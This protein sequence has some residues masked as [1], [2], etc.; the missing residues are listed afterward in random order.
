MLKTMRDSF[1]HLKWTLW[2]VVIVFILGFV[3][4]S[5]SSPNPADRASQVVARI[6]SDEITGAEFE[7]TYQARL[8][9]YRQQYRGSLTPEMLRYLD[10][11]RQ[12]LEGMI[13]RRLELEQ[14]RR[15]KLSVGNDEVARAVMA[16][17]AFQ[18]DGR[19]I[20]RE[21]Y[22]QL[23]FRY[24]YTPERFEEE[25]REDLLAG[26][27]AE[28]VRA[29]I[30]VP[31]PE[32][33]REFAVRNEKATIEYILVPS[34]RLES[35]VQPTDADLKAYAEKHR[36]RY[37]KP[38]QRRIKYL[39]IDQ[40]KVRAKVAPTDAELRAEYEQRREGLKVPEQV[41]AAHILI[42]SDST[43]GAEADAAA[44]AKAEKLAARARAG[45]DFA[46]L[47]R[48]SSEDTANKDS[49]GQL[50]PFSRGQMVPEF[51]QAAFALSPGQIAGP[52]K[53][54]F[55]YHVIKLVSKNPEHLQSFEEA[56]GALAADLTQ[57]KAAAEVSR[58][59]RELS[60]KVRKLGSASDEEL[61]KLQNDVVTFNTTPWVA[62]GEAIPGV[63]ANAD[64]AQE[65]FSLKL[66]QIS[67]S[68]VSTARGPAIVKPAEQR[69][70]GVPPFDELKER[71][72]AD[73]KTDRR[74]K[75]AL[76]K[77]QP[78]ARE[79]ASGTPLPQV[80]ARYDTE[81]KTT[82]E[83]APGGPIP[84]IGNAP[85][86]S[87]AVFKTAQGQTG[88]PTPVPGG[89]VL[90]RVIERKTADPKAFE[91][92]KAE[93]AEAVRAREGEK[94]LRSSLEQLRTER[95]VEINEE[96]LRSF[97]PEERRG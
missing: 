77:L 52:V 20:G 45:E 11:P 89:F 55:G 48:E 7:R 43:K 44:R 47:A 78:A 80:A 79:I 28:L 17:P 70:A 16:Y 14:A 29:S 88:A 87:S 22:V 9:S 37:R 67:K 83:F 86:L 19:F 90:F 49:G 51:E 57:R 97:L 96:L 46:K 27:Y 59:A 61:R 2:A 62:R 24:G 92:Q 68:A 85:E 94:L 42:K 71:V 1:H 75:E 33:V 36:D 60:E 41:V 5:G 53:T 40:A 34:S 58:L 39:L 76:E 74:E 6:G 12:V 63:G 8:E 18:Q 95:K 23:L 65:A 25:L 81:V 50:P 21:K 64:F 4:F 30:L 38:E 35:A 84:E 91:A 15:L 3:Y 82:P 73:W 69:P 13:S 31:E 93:L 32:L 10:L 56:R 54:Q 26:K 72:A 66:G